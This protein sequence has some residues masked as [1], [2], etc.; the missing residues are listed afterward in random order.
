M[1][2]LLGRKIPGNRQTNVK[3]HMQRAKRIAGTLWKCYQIGPYQYQLKHL[4]WYLSSQTSHLK[5]GICY[6]HWLTVKNIV[7]ALDKEDAWFGQLRGPW[8]SPARGKTFGEDEGNR[9][10]GD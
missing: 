6:R 10:L 5:P 1:E 4:K 7:K 3:K 2:Y 8:A 9:N